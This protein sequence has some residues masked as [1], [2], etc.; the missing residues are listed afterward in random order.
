MDSILSTSFQAD[1]EMYTIAVSVM[2]GRCVEFARLALSHAVRAAEAEAG[3]A[4]EWSEEL[5]WNI[6]NDL[7]EYEAFEVGCV[8]YEPEVVCDVTVKRFANDFTFSRATFTVSPRKGEV[9]TIECE[10]ME[11]M[12]YALNRLAKE[13]VTFCKSAKPSGK[14]W[15]TWL[16]TLI[17]SML[18]MQSAG[19]TT[20]PVVSV[21]QVPRISTVVPN[22]FGPPYLG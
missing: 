19:I 6:A 17:T 21:E 7:S 22:S 14:K 15:R 10:S 12:Q 8:G 18:A 9:V 4:S 20:T 11:Q 1:D 16:V 2:L 3:D 13:I 5:T